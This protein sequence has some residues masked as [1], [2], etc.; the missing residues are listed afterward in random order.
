[1]RA[2]AD[3]DEALERWAVESR[4]WQAIRDELLERGQ[5]PSALDVTD[6]QRRRMKLRGQV[7]MLENE[8]DRAALEL[9]PRRAKYL[10][11]ASHLRVVK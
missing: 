10:E 9:P 3:P 11:R 7:P 2:K 5:T 1:M 6:E 4:E 8:A